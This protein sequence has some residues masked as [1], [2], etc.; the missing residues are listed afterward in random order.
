MKKEIKTAECCEKKDQKKYRCNCGGNNGSNGAIYGLSV[1][2][3]LF[4]FLSKATGFSMV[5]VGIGKSIFWPAVLMFKLLT[6]L[7]M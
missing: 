1:I 6:Y 7:G 3:A 5:M 2:G 4:Y